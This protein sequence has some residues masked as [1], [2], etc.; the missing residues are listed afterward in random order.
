MNETSYEIKMADLDSGVSVFFESSQL[1]KD[2][3]AEER[4]LCAQIATPKNV[5]DVVKGKSDF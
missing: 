1:A 4:A 3:G 2:G 5:L